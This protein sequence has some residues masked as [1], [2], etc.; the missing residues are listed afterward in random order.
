MKDL[1]GWRGGSFVAGQTR[2]VPRAASQ[3][4]PP[5]R[6]THEGL[7]RVYSRLAFRSANDAVPREYS[8]L[9]N[10]L[11]IAELAG[12]FKRPIHLRII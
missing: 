12:R 6:K 1:F 3:G 7:D 11:P 2:R 10:C 5:P 4:T 9:Q 8:S